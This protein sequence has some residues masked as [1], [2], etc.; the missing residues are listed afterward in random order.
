M[1]EFEQN[2]PM[3]AFIAGFIILLLISSFLRN[4]F[5]NQK[6]KREGQIFTEGGRVPTIEERLSGNR[7]W[8]NGEIRSKGRALM[9]AVWLTAIVMN[10]TLGLSFIKSFSNPAI[11]TPALIMLG[12]FAAMGLGFIVFA[13]RL[14]MRYLRFGESRCRIEGKA[15]I[16]GST[17]KGVVQNDNIIEPTGDYTIELVCLDTFTVGSGKNRRTESRVQW[18][19]KQNVSHLGKNIK[20]GIPFSFELPKYPPE[21]G[22][23]LARGNINWQLR[24]RA[25]VDGVDY[26]ADFVVPVFKVDYSE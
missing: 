15:G 8:A 7:S 17:I 1:T 2:I 3:S 21:T 25:P 13:V 9:L 24:I 19:G 4:I 14:S 10:L 22:Y 26:A 6:L 12:I 16:L 5:R 11:K 20:L 18:Q 23:Q